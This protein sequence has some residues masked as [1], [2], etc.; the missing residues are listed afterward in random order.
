MAR[1]HGQNHMTAAIAKEARFRKP[2]VGDVLPLFS[3]F[4][5]SPYIVAAGVAR[6][7]ARAVERR[8][9]HTP[10]DPAQG[11]ADVDGPI[12][13]SPRGLRQEEPLGRLLK[14]R[15]VRNGVQL[16]RLAPLGRIGEHRRELAIVQL[17][18]FF[19]HQA[20]EE[21]RLSELFRAKAM[22]IPRQ[23]ELGSDVREDQS[24]SG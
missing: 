7:E 22:R 5:S 19:Q 3:A 10:L 21:L 4:F 6:L 1:H 9:G 23:R 18:E 12:Q 24:S 11:H 2:S 14:G 15:E 20:S 17:Q 16:D 8:Q 13:K